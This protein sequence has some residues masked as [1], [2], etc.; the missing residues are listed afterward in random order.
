MNLAKYTL[1]FIVFCLTNCKESDHEDFSNQKHDFFIIG[2]NDAIDFDQGRV[3]LPMLSHQLHIRVTL[4]ESFEVVK[5]ISFQN[6]E[7]IPDT[8]VFPGMPEGNF[9]LYAYTSWELSANFE[10]ADSL[11]V[12]VFLNNPF[13]VEIP[14]YASF[15]NFNISE[16]S[17]IVQVEMKNVT[18]Q[19]N[20]QFKEDVV[21]ENANDRIDVNS[22]TDQ[23]YY[24]F[25]T[26][27]YVEAK[28]TTGLSIPFFTPDD[29]W[30]MFE[31]PGNFYG[32][33]VVYN[34]TNPWSKT[35][36]F[37]EPLK[38][39]R[40]EQITFTFDIEAMKN[41]APGGAVVFEDIVWIDR[42]EVIIE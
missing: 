4:A 23:H 8:I 29:S 33:E 22:I 16:E 9:D 30:N 2:I 24:Q 32:F 6:G 5:Q 17:S 40:D 41:S 3:E 27:S 14:I 36:M 34:G 1:L 31:M 10:L 38:L 18:T 21:Y 20:Y 39:E 25:I 37:D 35:I 28:D 26:D 13:E 12:P 19:V 15:Q 42:G 11:N 7:T